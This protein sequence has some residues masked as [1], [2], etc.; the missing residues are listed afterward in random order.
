MALLQTAFVAACIALVLCVPALAED[1][2]PSTTPSDTPGPARDI[3]KN[4]LTPEE[5]AEKQARKACKVKI[6]DILAT[7]DPQGDDVSCDIV[8]TWREQD[9]TKMLGGRFDWT[10]GKAVC[11]S[12]LEVKRAALVKAMTQANYEVILPEQNVR[13]ALAQKSEGEPYSVDISIAPKVAF[14]NGKAVSARLN[15]GEAKAPMLAYA[16][17]YAG[18]GLDN[19]ANVLG[20]EVTRMVNEFTTKKCAKLKD[21]SPRNTGN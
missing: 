5:R 6:C 18:T 1:P 8:K 21:D 9:I 16:L 11:Q 17:I 3:G 10:W 13:C 14:E 15:W 19:S 7:K 2:S 20:P 12:K 4:D